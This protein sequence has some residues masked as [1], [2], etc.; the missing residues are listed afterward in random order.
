MGADPGWR[1]QEDG[2]GS[3]ARGR[4]PLLVHGRSPLSPGSGSRA[5]SGDGPRPGEALIHGRS[6][7]SPGTSRGALIEALER[8]AWRRSP[9]TERER[10]VRDG[11]QASQNLSGVRLTPVRTGRA[12]E[13]LM[14]EGKGRDARVGVGAGDERCAVGG[15]GRGGVATEAAAEKAPG[16]GWKGGLRAR[17]RR[18]QKHGENWRKVRA[19]VVAGVE[20]SRLERQGRGEVGRG[21]EFAQVVRAALAA[22]RADRARRGSLTYTME[23]NVQRRLLLDKAMRTERK[24]HNT[25]RVCLDRAASRAADFGGGRSL[26]DGDAAEDGDDEEEDDDTTPVQRQRNKAAFVTPSYKHLAKFGSGERDTDGSAESAEGRS[27]AAR[28]NVNHTRLMYLIS[29]YSESNEDGQFDTWIRKLPVL[30]LLYEGT[31]APPGGKGEPVFDYDYAPAP[32]MVQGKNVHLNVTQEGR[33]DLDDLREE[34]MLHGLTL[35][36]KG[37]YSTVAIRPTAMGYAFLRETLTAQDVAA[38][39]R[40]IYAPCADL[41]ADQGAVKGKGEAKP[42]ELLMVRWDERSGRFILATASGSYARVSDVTDLECVSFV[43]SPYVSSSCRKHCSETVA[44]PHARVG[45]RVAELATAKSTV[46][47]PKLDENLVVD[48][49]TLFLAEWVPTGS[50]TLLSL[51]EKLGA[52]DGDGA[53]ATGMLFTAARDPDPAGSGFLAHEDARKAGD[54]WGDKRRPTPQGS[55]VLVL[56]VDADECAGTMH[57]QDTVARVRV[58][59]YDDAEFVNFEA[60]VLFER[61]PGVLQVE[62]CGVHMESRGMCVFGSMLEGVMRSDGRR[63]V[64]LDNLARVIAGCRV[65]SSRVL[66]TLLTQQQGTMLDLA[67]LGDRGAREKYVALV[68]SRL[69]CR[70]TGLD[71]GDMEAAAFMDKETNENELK[72][73]IG[74]T[75]AAYDLASDLLLVTGRSGVLL[76]GPDA[77]RHEAV[78]LAYLGLMTRNLFMRSLFSRLFVLQDF[79]KTIRNRVVLDSHSDPNVVERVRSDL[80]RAQEHVIMLGEIQ[81]HL[82]E[83]LVGLI[84]T[85]PR[86][87]P[88]S[89]GDEAA[90]RLHRVVRLKTTLRR[91]RRR[92]HDILKNLDAARNE[93][94]ALQNMANV[95]NANAAAR[96]LEATVQNSRNMEDVFRAKE[97]SSTAF[98]VMQVV[99]AGSLAFSV[100]DRVHGLYLGIAADIDWATGPYFRWFY[101]SPGTVFVFN[102]AVWLVLAVFLTR[103]ADRLQERARGVQAVSLR[104][105]APCDIAALQDLL[106]TRDMTLDETEATGDGKV[107]RKYTWQEVDRVRWRGDPPSVEVT[108]DEQHGFMLKAYITG[109]YKWCAL[110]DKG[111]TNAFHATM[112]EAGVLDDECGYSGGGSR[113]A[114]SQLPAAA[115]SGTRECAEPWCSDD[116]ENDGGDGMWNR[117]CDEDDD[118]VG[119]AAGDVICEGSPLLPSM[120]LKRLSGD[121]GS[122]TP[123]GSGGTPRW[124]ERAAS[125]AATGHSG[126]LAGFPVSSPRKSVMDDARLDDVALHIPCQSVHGGVAPTY[127]PHV[128]NQPDMLSAFMPRAD[129]P[130]LRR[131]LAG[132]FG[133]ATPLACREDVPGLSDEGDDDDDDDDNDVQDRKMEE[134]MQEGGE[135]KEEE[136]SEG[137]GGEAPHGSALLLRDVSNRQFRT[138][139]KRE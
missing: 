21:Y 133:S 68:C 46:R 62:H 52:G 32:V 50:N 101:E 56:G 132:L 23:C 74:D 73:V 137:V 8:D 91:L 34:G 59:D 100:L 115:A 60:E 136:E 107:I 49:V 127:T 11:L 35:D 135:E 6:P 41:D 25:W 69:L 1:G 9:R 97:R 76:A 87:P 123:P 122:S 92:V 63:G 80:S 93:V 15:E 71:Q 138:P 3:S 126:S 82:E 64:S 77:R 18:S 78:M 84:D 66:D 38:V 83:S 51:N 4:S 85:L 44:D 12:R 61:P 81:A 130:S 22:A 113:T 124:L 13:A 134:E 47:D 31:V 128:V 120:P 20:R 103:F 139:R 19:M 70:A 16:R 105:N 95:L 111:L 48:D 54:A 86:P 17:T 89:A 43:S 45:S 119:I 28:L 24:R 108:V 42:R 112:R 106:A 36:S 40:L 7:L 94:R 102:M 72:Q 114:A 129:Q 29:C 26:F 65:D 88:K 121:T 131:K 33:D 118:G 27:A 104:L 98:Q 110:D 14:G 75:Y 39:D 5:V 58:L 67:Y 53:Q 117:P 10:V 79:L 30:I 90:R 109:S 116:D 125:L 37:F 99:L 96:V 2:D 57:A 55:S